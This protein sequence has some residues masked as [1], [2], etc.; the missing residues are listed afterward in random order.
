MS[1]GPSQMDLFDHKPIL[2]R[3]HGEEVPPSV[4][5]SRRGVTTMTRNQG[6]FQAAATPYRFRRHGQSGAEMSDLLPHMA[7]VADE[8]C[9]VRSLHTEPINHDP[10]VT[11]MQCGRA[12]AGLPCMGAWLS[13]G[14]GSANRDLPAFVVMI[15]GPL[16]Q[17][18]PSRYYHSGFLPSQHQG[19]QFQA[20][21][22]P[23]HYLSDLP[24]VSRRARG[25]IKPRASTS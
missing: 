20:T 5:G 23:V 6:H 7:T 1:G 22:D 18:V 16:D 19:V 9:I 3:R 11:F 21:G 24:G 14:L 2:Y 17:P 10:A 25:G 13:Y 8:L 4:L 12:Q 15:S